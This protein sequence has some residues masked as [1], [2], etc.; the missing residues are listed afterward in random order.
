MS[1]PRVLL[2]DDDSRIRQAIEQILTPDYEIVAAVGDGRAAVESVERHRPD[3]VLLDISMP[4]MNGFKVARQLRQSTPETQI[5]FVTS[6]TDAAYV[7]E[8]FQAGAAAYVAKRSMR[9]DL[10]TAIREVLSGRTYRPI[11]LT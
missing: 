11:R 10:S 5:I 6:Q 2:A 9:S 1:R 4:G 3:V 8:A 7:E